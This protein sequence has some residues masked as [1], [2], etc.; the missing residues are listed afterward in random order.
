MSYEYKYTKLTVI[1][2]A[3]N[4][5]RESMPYHHQFDSIGLIEDCELSTM[6]ALGND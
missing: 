3:L 4:F 2:G 1:N 5:D 6:E